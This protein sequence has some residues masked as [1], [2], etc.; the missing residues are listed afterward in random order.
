M[1]LQRGKE[2]PTVV[3]LGEILWDCLPSGRRLG[4]APANFAYCSHLL[5]NRAIVASRIGRDELGSEIRRSLARAGMADEFLQDDT[6]HPTGTVRVELDATG[7]PS[8]SISQP[9]AWDFLEWSEPW[10]TLARSADAVAF[11]TLAQR[12]KESR[13][14]IRRFLEATRAASL[15]VFDINLRQNF[16]SPRLLEASFER[17]NVVKLNHE[18]LSPVQ[19]LLETSGEDEVSLCRKWIKRFHLQLVC[20]T[21]GASGSLIV[22]DRAFDEHPGL[23]V[24]VKDTV[25]AGDAFTAGLVDAYLRGGTLVQLNHSANRMGAWVASHSGAM[26]AAPEGEMERVMGELE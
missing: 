20:V 2:L 8:Y 19:E 26:P 5:G 3:G 24:E 15:R 17:A 16:Y 22:D 21:R 6:L 23:R 1:Q 10:E 4:G 13:R 18:E 12:S 14:T 25:G 11:G 9:A 7:Q